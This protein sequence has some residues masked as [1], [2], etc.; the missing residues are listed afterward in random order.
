MSSTGTVYNRANSPSI[1]TDFISNMVRRPVFI[2]RDADSPGPIIR[3]GPN[4][5]HISDPDYYGELTAMKHRLDKDPR[6]YRFMGSTEASFSTPSWELH[7]K[8]RSKENPFFSRAMVDQLEPVVGR[9]VQ[10]LCDRLVNTM[11]EVVDIHCAFRSLTADIVTEYCFKES[12]NFLAAPDFSRSYHR[13]SDAFS[14]TLGWMRNI[15]YLA[16]VLLS[17]PEDWVKTSSTD[18]IFKFRNVSDKF[19]SSKGD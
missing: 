8:R 11:G 15:K 4:E 1:V 7:R 6:F 16:N 2:W 5:V 13:A 12:F 10:D 17:L 18:G 14:G 19:Y 9:F 3:I